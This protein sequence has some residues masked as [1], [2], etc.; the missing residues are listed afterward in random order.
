MTTAYLVSVSALFFGA[1]AA[2]AWR[3]TSDHYRFRLSEATQRLATYQAWWER[4]SGKA[5]IAQAELDLI[6]EQ[7][8]SAG[9]QSHKVEKA[10]FAD[11]ALW[12]SEQPVQPL[13]PRAEI[14]AEVAARRAARANEV[15]PVAFSSPAGIPAEAQRSPIKG[16]SGECTPSKPTGRGRGVLPPTQQAAPQRQFGRRSCPTNRAVESASAE[17]P[18]QKGAI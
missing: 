14:E 8:R 6:A 3:L 5:L 7:R 18:Q 17:F 15:L 11:T 9:R 12:L 2:V 1:G 16:G 13:R 10:R 4:D